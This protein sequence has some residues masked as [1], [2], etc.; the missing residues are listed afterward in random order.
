MKP[1][2]E[3]ILTPALFSLY[4]KQFA[5]SNVVVIDILR[6]TTTICVA[7]ENGAREIVPVAT[8]EQAMVYSGQGFLVAAERNGVTVDGFHL[9]N[10]PQQYTRD[11]VENKHIAFTTTNGTKWK[12]RKAMVIK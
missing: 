12:K 4:E 10:S 9:G 2:V 11:L 5:T 7:F 1:V 8:P 6:A 3:A